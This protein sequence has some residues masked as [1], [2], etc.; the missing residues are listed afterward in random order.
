MVP[1]ADL[2]IAFGYGGGVHF[3]HPRVDLLLIVIE[4]I[5]GRDLLRA[6]R[7]HGAGWRDA[8]PDLPRPRFLP[9][10][11]PALVELAP[12]LSDPVLGGVVRR[13]TVAGGEIEQE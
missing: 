13:V 6:R 12:K 2:V 11:V 5:P 10:L 1:S 4:R 3:H 9:H 7:E 8:E